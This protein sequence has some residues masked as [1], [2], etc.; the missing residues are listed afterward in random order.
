MKS[1]EF[2]LAAKIPGRPEK[3][4]FFVLGD[5]S[6]QSKDSRLWDGELLGQSGNAHRQGPVHLLAAFLGPRPI[7]SPVSPSPYRFRNR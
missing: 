5:N 3:D 7:P 1:V 4:Q 6:P 2:P